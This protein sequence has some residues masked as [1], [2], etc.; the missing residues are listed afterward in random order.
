MMYVVNLTES[1]RTGNINTDGSTTP[2]FASK[3]FDECVKV[4]REKE[5]ELYNKLLKEVKESK[6]ICGASFDGG[7]DDETS[8]YMYVEYKSYYGIIQKCEYKEE[9]ECQKK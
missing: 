4:L 2:L 5:G 6:E 9:S 3:D 1:R 8:F 7:K